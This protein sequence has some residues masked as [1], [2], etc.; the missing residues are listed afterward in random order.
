MPADDGIIASMLN[1]FLTAYLWVGVMAVVGCIA[2]IAAT[3]M[4]DELPRAL[5]AAWAA[6]DGLPPTDDPSAKAAS[7]PIWPVVLIMAIVFALCG[8]RY[9][10]GWHMALAAIFCAFLVVLAFIDAR[11]CL[12]PDILTL[13]LLWLGL[14]VSTQ[15][16][17]VSPVD[18]IWGAAWGY[19][20]LWL[21]YHAFR[22]ITGKEGMGYG[23][24]KLLAA[25][26]A[27]VGVDAV[28][29]VMLM[30][31]ITGIV[32]NVAMRLLGRAQAGQALPFGPALALA[33]VATLLWP[34][35]MTGPWG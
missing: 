13:P 15:T 12:L 27:W 34:A 16:L 19:G 23:D 35:W 9:D 14:L 25:I 2:G 30:A 11:T 5:L 22:L 31:A 17:W 21:V 20:V 32:I 24:F 8:W 29:M 3:G 33:G 18:A 1:E 28:S 6:Q 4:I 7:G 26:G 10:P